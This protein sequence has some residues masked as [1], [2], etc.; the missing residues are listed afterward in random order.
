MIPPAGRECKEIKLDG[1]MVNR[2]KDQATGNGVSLSL[3]EIERELRWSP[4]HPVHLRQYGTSL[5][6][7]GYVEQARTVL[8]R[9]LSLVPSL[10]TL[11][12]LV[13]L[14]LAED[15]PFLAIR[16]LKKALAAGQTDAGLQN[17]L[18]ELQRRY[19]AHSVTFYIPCY[20]QE[21]YLV[22]C[23]ESILRQSYP[24]EE[25]L[26]IDDGSTDNSAAIAARYPVRI[27]RHERNLGLAAAR[28]S[29]IRNARGDFLAAV[30]TD[31]VPEDTWLE[32]IMANFSGASVGGV[33]GKLLE[34]H[35]GTVADRWRQVHMQ[36]HWGE[37][38]KKITKPDF[39]FG[40]GS[41]FR[42]SALRD[43]GGYDE[44][45][46]TNGEDTHISYKLDE[47]GWTLR[48]EPLARVRHLRRDD[49][50]SVLNTHWRYLK[51]FFEMGGAYA[52][53]NT[54]QQKIESDICRCLE[55]L[56]EDLT[57]KN[58]HIAYPSFLAP[59]WF[60]FANLCH[61]FRLALFP[62]D[63]IVQTLAAVVGFLEPFLRKAP[64]CPEVLARHLLAD[65]KRLLGQYLRDDETW[66]VEEGRLG[67]LFEDRKPPFDRSLSRRME[68][69]VM[70]RLPLADIRTF[71]NIIW[72]FHD[73][74]VKLDP[75]VL[76]MIETSR[77]R[78]E[79]EACQSLPEGAF[80]VV[81]VNP[82]WT[83]DGRQ[84]VR[85][86]SR[87]PFTS[88]ACNHSSPDY[89][90]FP[91]FLAYATSRLKELGFEAFIV[92]AVAEGLSPEEF[93]DRVIG[94]SPHLILMECSTP[95]IQFDL[96]C[97]R[98]LK[99]ALPTS[100]LALTG[101]HVTALG[102][103]FLEGNAL[104]DS[105]ILGEYEVA[106][107]ELAQQLK[108]NGDLSAVR[109]LLYRDEA[110][111]VQGTEERTEEVDIR[112]LPLPERL[113][114]PMYNCFDGFAGM[115]W[116]NVQMHASRGCPF[117]CVFCVWPQILYGSK[118]YRIREPMQ[119]IDE[120][121]ML[122]RDYGFKAV[123]FDDDTFNIGKERIQALCQEIRRRGIT[124]P[125]AAMARADTSDY[126]TL[127]HMKDAGLCAIKFGVESGVQQIVDQCEK[128]LNLD[129]V[130]EAVGWCKELGIPVHLTFTLG[131]PGES[132]D[133][134]QQTIEYVIALDPD[135]V[136]FSLTTPFPGTKYFNI[137]K[138]R[139][140]LLTEDWSKYDGACHTVI[141][142]ENLSREELEWSVKEAQRQWALHKSFKRAVPC[143]VRSAAP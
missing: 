8:E 55:W 128:G 88:P 22:G 117:G 7:N 133:T 114:L 52:G 32:R 86:G 126:E 102:K 46:R 112:Q 12:I 40:A 118:R 68:Q 121:E 111:A 34:V 50:C 64:G 62:R 98:R 87:W 5:W 122:I 2:M 18:Q 39:L 79:Y 90:P 45:L 61:M 116:P 47:A 92:D 9:L 25:I 139:G 71:R 6:Q 27:I 103:K 130:N 96:A 14:N 70:A 11:Q 125:W 4:E 100:H 83:I 120:M 80:R 53:F 142:G 67:D 104:V 93:L 20:N 26:V 131:L 38:S 108:D 51:P 72:A 1:S 136:Q 44:R 3:E 29:A 42:T 82:P 10:E 74:V 58:F 115:P 41:V 95:S 106:A 81:L 33:C 105:I 140:L 37:D 91:F 99:L 59:F 85:A 30:D 73:L 48:Y 109:G 66:V 101:T 60:T 43:V 129:K 28:N 36:Q 135:S 49:L 23:I 110:G 124:V 19:P 138:E 13:E 76:K 132:R 134:I 84:G 16:T 127:R 24:V 15:L 54:V 17:R 63:E 94:F 137:L 89:L 143:Q 35:T 77:R 141:R 75:L 97:A 113:T 31:A 123:Y 119:V 56:H 57:T 69:K 107:G 78:I 65:L 21:E